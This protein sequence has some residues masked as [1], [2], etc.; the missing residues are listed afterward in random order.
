MSWPLWDVLCLILSPIWWLS[1]EARS[2][3]HC[4]GGMQVQPQ[5]TGMDEGPHFSGQGSSRSLSWGNLRIFILAEKSDGELP[6]SGLRP[7]QWALC[8]G[9]AESSLDLRCWAR[10][11]G[12]AHRHGGER[13]PHPRRGIRTGHGGVSWSLLP[14]AL[15]SRLRS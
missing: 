6:R 10:G 7:S 8:P 14:S 5:I 12:R 13:A 9:Q 15:E 1:S 2:W 3:R 4:P 11:P